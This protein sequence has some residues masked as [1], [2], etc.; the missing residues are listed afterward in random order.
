MCLL[1][2]NLCQVS[3]LGSL[4]EGWVDK[5][6]GASLASCAKPSEKSA[7]E[8]ENKKSTKSVASGKVQLVWPTVEFVRVL[9]DG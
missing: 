1:L 2:A 8:T 6:F 3:S 7:N 4:T 5:E 9:L